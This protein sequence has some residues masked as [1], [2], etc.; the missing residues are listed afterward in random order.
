MGCASSSPVVEDAAI[1]ELH[2]TWRRCVVP[3]PPREKLCA[4]DLTWQ[5]CFCG[6]V[7]PCGT[8]RVLSETHSQRRPARPSSCNLSI[9][10]GSDDVSQRTSAAKRA[11]SPSDLPTIASGLDSE[12]SEQNS[13]NAESPEIGTGVSAELSSQLLAGPDHDDDGSP[14]KSRG[15]ERRLGYGVEVVREQIRRMAVG[16]PQ[17]EADRANLYEVSS[18]E[19]SDVEQQYHRALTTRSVVSMG[20]V[21]KPEGV[22]DA[23]CSALS[24]NLVFRGINQQLLQQV[25]DRMYGVSYPKGVTVV[26]QGEHADE[27]FDCMYFL[28]KGEVDVVI[29]GNVTRGTSGEAQKIEGNSA[30]I[31]KGPGWVFGDVALLFNTPRTA[32]VITS[33]PSTMWL[34]ER[35]TFL[36]FVM[37][38]APG[39]RTLRFVRKLPLL[40][41]LSDNVLLNVAERLEEKVYQDGESII[42][43]G[44]R[45]DQLYLIRYGT[46]RVLRPGDGAG[47][48][49]EV[50]CLG[51]GQFVGERTLVTG[52]LRSA[53]CE[54]SGEVRVVVINKKDFWDLDNPLLAWML[55]YDA[56]TCVLKSLPQLQKLTQPQ[57]EQIIERFDY[58]QEVTEGDVIL[59]EGQLVDKLYVVKNG[60]LEVSE[61]VKTLS[62]SNISFIQE[63]GGF[64]YF[65]EDVLAGINPSPVTVTI[66]SET[67]Q[68]LTLRRSELDDFLGPAQGAP[69]AV[70]PRDIPAVTSMLGKL[71][72][73]ELLEAEE[74]GAMARNIEFREY[75]EGDIVVWQGKPMNE[76]LLV[77]SGRCLVTQESVSPGSRMQTLEAGRNSP[78]ELRSGDAYGEDALMGNAAVW[79]DTLVASFP[80]TQVLLVQKDA[81]EVA[82]GQPLAD[83]L[84]ERRK[85]KNLSRVPSR[86][87]ESSIRF[88]DLE[89]LRIVGTG[90]FGLVRV[91]RHV[92]TGQVYALKVMHKGPITESKQVEH[93]VNERDIL[94]EANHPFCVGL[95]NAYQDQSSLYLLQ[96][97]V[98]GGELFHHLDLEGSFDEPTA[99]FFAANVLLALEFLHSKGIVYRDLKPE[100]LLLDVDGYIKV[101][102]FGF[103]KKIGRE[104]TFTI[105]GT[106]DYQAPEVIMRRGTSK[107]ADYWGLGVLIFEM[108]VGDPPFKSVSGDP[109]D[110]FRRTLSGRFYVPNFISAEAA[111]LIYKLLQVNPERRLGSGRGGAED[112]KHHRWFAQV[113]WAGLKEKTIPAPIKPRLRNMLDT[114]NFDVFDNVETP[115]HIRAESCDR[116][117][118]GDTMWEWVDNSF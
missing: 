118:W 47:Q 2:D 116:S 34:L 49:I 56:V 19:D 97:W 62:R 71:S 89:Q 114:S 3:A 7:G 44:E 100:N 93:V 102:D 111:D 112:I 86:Q 58:R 32:S 70:Q 15:K 64:N 108:L 72:L 14:E 81:V 67:A 73:L 28:E 74:L 42:R 83:L 80:K 85:K 53:D 101:A 84:S 31:H 36:R 117:Q 30:V 75:N 9:K 109:W 98:P 107:A 50:A 23:I 54:A 77:K 25:V 38:H 46:V 35:R 61:S 41:G 39:A 105:C 18:S 99:M 55:D 115:P 104:R 29:S 45:G 96:E 6:A 82:L 65:G 68:L 92:I 27:E 91:V 1:V 10:S 8:P 76:M 66:K 110:T 78:A 94:E 24:Q 63:A 69:F 43:Y 12:T 20:P 5:S 48:R 40:K 22:M 90:Q 17:T 26:Q 106:P 59:H 11:L 87:L 57:L 103:A 51:R 60:D 37:R 88:Q 33:A 79:E 16:G 21:E 113:D 95:V 13:N 4:P 52:K